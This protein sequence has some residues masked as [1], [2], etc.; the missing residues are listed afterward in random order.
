MVIN[1]EFLNWC[2][3]KWENEFKAQKLLNS[4]NN[5][6]DKLKENINK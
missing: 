1:E 2:E 6:I 4:I 5:E 3:S